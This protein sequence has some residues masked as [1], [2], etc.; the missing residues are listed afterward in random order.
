MKMPDFF[1]CQIASLSLHQ[2]CKNEVC[3]I[4]VLISSRLEAVVA[5]QQEDW[6]QKVRVRC[7]EGPAAR[8]AAREA[9]Q[10]S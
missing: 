10:G 5:Q 4:V 1:I 6:Y 2:V 3:I 8:A 7:C 9:V